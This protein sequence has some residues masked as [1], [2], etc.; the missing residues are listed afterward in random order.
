MLNDKHAGSG[1]HKRAV[2]CRRA[3]VYNLTYPATKATPWPVNSTTCFATYDFF[4]VTKR[5]ANAIASHLA[6]S[7]LTAPDVEAWTQRRDEAAQ[8]SGQRRPSEKT[9]ALVLG[10]LERRKAA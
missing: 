5:K 7:G 6:T 10:K 3:A 9:W 1:L 4:H 8:L 2:P